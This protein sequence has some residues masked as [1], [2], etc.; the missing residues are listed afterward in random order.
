VTKVLISRDDAKPSA[1]QLPYPTRQSILAMWDNARDGLMA[2]LAGIEAFTGVKAF[3]AKT[4]FKDVEIE[5]ATSGGSTSLR[6]NNGNGTV[7]ELANDNA[8]EL[9]VTAGTGTPLRIDVAGADLAVQILAAAVQLG[10]NLDLAGNSV[11][12]IGNVNVP[13]GLLQLDGNGKVGASQLTVDAMQW[14]G[15]WNASTNTPTLADGAGSPGDVYRVT[16]AGTRNLG[17]G[18]QTFDVGDWVILNASSVWEKA[19]MTDA[20]SSVAGLTGIVTA[21]QIKAALAQ[22]TGTV[23]STATPSINCDNV[24]FY[25]IT[26]LAAAITGVTVTGTPAPGQKLMIR[27]K[28]NGSARAIS[29]GSQFQASGVASLPTTTAAGKTHHIGFVYDE[30]ATKWTCLAADVLGY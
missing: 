14:K 8:G 4:W 28:D 25:T 6:M 9:S 24:Q 10:A 22:M 27:I 18:S 12:N 23:T 19:D 7:W 16:I 29:W 3:V 1:D 15:V 30:V 2:H 5:P 17:S 21:A 26:A 20:V 11:L 13:N